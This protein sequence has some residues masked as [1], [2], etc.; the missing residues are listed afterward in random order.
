MFEV[1]V[2]VTHLELLEK[3]MDLPIRIGSRIVA[4]IEERQGG[5]SVS[6]WGYEDEYLLAL[7][8][9]KNH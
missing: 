6:S 1:V 4:L 7:L 3:Q 8:N 9:I 5:Y 2:G